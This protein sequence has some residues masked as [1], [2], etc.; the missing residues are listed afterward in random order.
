MVQL[1]T[2]S[3]IE[4]P[5]SKTKTFLLEYKTHPSSTLGSVDRLMVRANGDKTLE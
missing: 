2:L 4:C 5:N 1:Q 3:E